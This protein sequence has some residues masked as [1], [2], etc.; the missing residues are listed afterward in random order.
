[1]THF[2]VLW[3]TRKP[4]GD[5]WVTKE[6]KRSFLASGT[7]I[8]QRYY[9]ANKIDYRNQYLTA[10]NEPTDLD[11][12]TTVFNKSDI[13]K[14]IKSVNTAPRTASNTVEDID[15]LRSTETLEAVDDELLAGEGVT[16]FD[17]IEEDIDTRLDTTEVEIVKALRKIEKKRKESRLLSRNPRPVWT[18]AEKHM[19][20]KFEEKFCTEKG[21]YK[22]YVGIYADQ[23]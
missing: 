17:C 1:M 14:L 4:N 13:H 6:P 19:R 23:I 18:E 21:S 7:W 15:I 2:Y 9:R 3:L 5:L 10:L 11:A 22:Y 8:A 20:T 12:A 16:D